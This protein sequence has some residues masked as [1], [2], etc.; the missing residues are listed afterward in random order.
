MTHTAAMVAY[1]TRMV[2][3]AAAMEAN[4]TATEGDLLSGL[5]RRRTLENGR[6]PSRAKA[7]VMRE[8]DVRAARPQR[9][10]AMTMSTSSAHANVDGS[11]DF[12]VHGTT[13]A[14]WATPSG[15]D[16]MAS[17]MAAIITQ[18]KRPETH[19]ERTMPF[20]AFTAALT[21]SSLVCAEASKPVMVYA[22]SRNPSAKSQTR[23]SCR[24]NT[25]FSPSGR[26]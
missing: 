26:P 1:G 19:T 4:H 20:G 24:G 5:T 10:C 25:G 23:F 8:V 15:T 9:Y 13:A 16:G 21:V 7:K 14:P 22:G 18:P 6:P 2:K 17:R 11:T 12:M 3:S